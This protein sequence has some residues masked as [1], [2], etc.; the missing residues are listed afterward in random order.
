MLIP[1]GYGHETPRQQ[2][3]IPSQWESGRRGA[4]KKGGRRDETSNI[5]GQWNGLSVGAGWGSIGEY[6]S[7]SVDI[8]SFIPLYRCPIRIR[9]NSG[10]ILTAGVSA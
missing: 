3:A 1:L 10:Y 2:R 4:G 5:S 6:Q 7:I 8:L 9:V